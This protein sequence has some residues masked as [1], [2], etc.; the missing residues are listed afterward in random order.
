MSI[1][2]QFRCPGGIY[3]KFNDFDNQMMSTDIRR[4]HP[5]LCSYEKSRWYYISFVVLVESTVNLM[6]LITKWCLQTF[7]EITRCY[8]YGKTMAILH[9]FRCPGGIYCKFND[10]DNQMMSTDIRRNH[11]MLWSLENYGDITSVS[12]PWW[13]LL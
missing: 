3:C 2:Q 10:F 6:I 12:L 9:Q 4:N 1:L 8:G 7:V 11:P 13:N 5:M